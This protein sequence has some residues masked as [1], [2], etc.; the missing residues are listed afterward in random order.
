MALGAGIE[1]LGSHEVV[2]DRPP[3]LTNHPA[4]RIDAKWEIPGGDVLEVNT[5]GNAPKSNRGK[6]PM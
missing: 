6:K 1:L 5:S 4:G 3:Q 2:S